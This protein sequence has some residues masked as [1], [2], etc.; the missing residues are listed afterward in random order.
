MLINA[1][2]I[3]GLPIIE[4]ITMNKIAMVSNLIVSPENGQILAFLLQK[5]FFSGENKIVVLN[6]IREMY[7]DGLV[8]N[9]QENIINS[10]EVVKVKDVLDKD[11]FLLGSRVMT[12]NGKKIGYLE[13]FIFDTSFSSIVTLIVKKR[14]SSEKRIISAERILNILPKRIV[15]RDMS[16][17]VEVSKLAKILEPILPA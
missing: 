6:D 1:K 15:I 17:K 10:N 12:Q 5:S 2:K 16:N 14:F 9:T 8:T 4:A 3:I 13:D 11:I 7:I